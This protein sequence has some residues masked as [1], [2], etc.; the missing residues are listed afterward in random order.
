MR[1]QGYQPSLDAARALTWGHFP[2][3][4]RTD[5]TECADL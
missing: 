2:A 5:L 4:L 1:R 3:G